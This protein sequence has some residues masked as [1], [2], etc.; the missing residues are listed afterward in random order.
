MTLQRQ[1]GFWL[2]ALAALVALVWLLNAILLPFIAGIVLAYF[3]DPVADALEQLG[4]P[5]VIASLAILI[6]A[7]LLFTLVLLL[8][9][10]VLGDQI[11]LFTQNL[12]TITDTLV[13]LLNDAVPDWLRDAVLGAGGT[14][15]SRTSE[16]TAKAAGWIAGFAGTFW[17]GGLAVV[18]MLS[19]MVVTPII[20]FYLLND[21]DRIVN[22]IDSWMPRPHLEVLRDI[23]RQIDDAMAGFI[24]GQGTV[25]ILLGLF[26]AVGLSF[27]GLSFGLLIGFTAGLLSFIPFAGSLI[28]GLAAIG[29]ALVQFW[30]DWPHVAIVAAIFFAGQFIEGNFLS[31]KLVG[32][33]VGLHPVWLMFSLFAFGYLFGFVGLLLAVPMAAAVGVL[34]RFALK[35]YL[36]SPLYLGQQRRSAKSGSLKK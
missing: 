7:I 23:A 21:W 20:A 13:R 36:A 11:S 5:R 12:P 27:A 26:Y 32:N 6:S 22:R 29:V 18:N 17:S 34:T 33:S 10:P 4:L 8:L 25:C 15:A 2:L 31:P 3:L 30:P 1:L 19:L 16:L 9:L 14:T 28:G 35:Q 24:R